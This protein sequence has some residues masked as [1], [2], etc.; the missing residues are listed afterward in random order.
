MK[1]KYIDLFAGLGGF[2]IALNKVCEKEGIETECV[3]VSEIDKEVI[4]TYQA[5]FGNNEK[6]INIRDLDDKCSQCPKHD[7]LFGGFPC[8]CFSNAGK[9]KGFLDQTRGTLF[10]DIVKILKNKKPK[11]ILLENVKHLTKH[12][13]GKTWKIICDTLDK[14]GYAIPNP[15]SPL[16]LSPHMFGIPQERNRVFIPGVLRSKM[17]KPSKYLN[18]DFSKY[19]KSI[20]KTRTKIERLILDKNVPNKYYLNPKNKKDSYLIR[21]FKMWDDFIKH[22][23]FPTPDTLP[24]IWTKDMRNP[25]IKPSFPNWKK[26]YLYKMNNFYLKNKTFIDKWYKKWNPN[27]FKIR[28]QKLEWQVGKDCNDIRQSII[29]LRQSG[30]RCKKFAKFPTL[31]AM[32][33]TTLIY[34]FSKKQWRHLTPR[35]MARLQSFPE[36]YT[37][38]NEVSKFYK[39]FYSYKQLGNSVNIHVVENVITE[40]LKRK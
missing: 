17:S 9:K 25:D 5:N 11:Y 18:F 7:I 33:Q 8:Q 6:I 21:A 12:D 27:K 2:R 28:E 13:G 22:V 19:F 29:T 26:L 37:L 32:V 23:E 16:I 35:E 36:K 20:P 38:Y 4:K 24:V 31:V 14:L 40:L 15:S 34:D 30:I 39:D 1:L 10:F 3:F